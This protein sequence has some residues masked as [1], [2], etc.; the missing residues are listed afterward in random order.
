M[1]K[2]L[3]K[4]NLAY[5]GLIGLLCAASLYF[6]YEIRWEFQTPEV[7]QEQR[8]S[9]MLWLI[10]LQ[11][12]VLY[13]FGQFEIM[14]ARM[15]SYDF[16][17]LAMALG[18]TAAFELYLWY[19][20]GGKDCPGR[21]IIL[22]D[23]MLALLFLGGL[24]ALLQ[25]IRGDAYGIKGRGGVLSHRVAIIGAGF[26]GNG[27]ALELLTKR[28]FGMTPVAFIDDD[29][30]KIGCTYCGVRVVGGIN[31]IVHAT[32]KFDLDRL[33]IAEPAISAARIREILLL[34]RREKLDLLIVPSPQELLNGQI[35]ADQLRPVELEDFLGRQSLDTDSIEAHALIAQKVVMVTGAG[36]SIGSELCR[37]IA[38]K[39]PHRLL[40]VDHS[41]VALFAIEQQLHS[42]GFNALILPLLA[43]VSDEKRMR[44]IMDR[45]RPQVI[46]HSAAYKH[47]P[48]I[49]QQPGEALKNN[50]LAT[51]QF[52]RMAIEFG[53]KRFVFISS[54][55]AINPTN[56][57]GA[58]KRLSEIYLQSLTQ[59]EGNKTEFMAVRFGNVLGS[60]GSVVPIFKNQ[61]RE[62]GP[63]TVTHPEVTRYFMSIPEAVGLVLQCASQGSG[64]EIFILDM[65]K[66]IKI[67]DL[68]RQLIE[69][70]GFEPDLD[71]EIKFVGL[72]PGEKLYEELHY[73]KE[74]E[75]VSTSHP[76][77]RR[78]TAKPTPL[79]QVESYFKELQE[80][81]ES[82]DRNQLKQLIQRYVPEYKPYLD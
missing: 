43:D 44:Y 45:Y 39:N 55:K 53:V 65:G 82:L 5:I 62:G 52:G 30:A 8:V 1:A 14:S 57:M 34:A 59:Q 71:I 80:Q 32:A 31:S 35:R 25:F 73:T 17:Q 3:P 74:E 23:F 48:L 13:A 19:V 75:Y 36:G 76:R 16:I 41:E 9:V 61:I 66:P 72:R 4:E 10:P 40:L 49:E 15:R 78:Y 60:S 47:V 69:L 56:A 63:V 67:V 46:F 42:E 18:L 22:I 33:I 68:A 29:P 20:F 11:M 38:A 6:A 2:P 12:V 24:R 28:G 7:F 77:V 51:A 54:D 79:E 21:S 26:V 81:C 58:S 70:S 27:L 50:T 64:G 37:Q